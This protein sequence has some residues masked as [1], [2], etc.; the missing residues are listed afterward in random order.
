MAACSLVGKYL[1]VERTYTG[2]IFQAEAEAE[3]EV[4]ALTRHR[5][6]I[7][8]VLTAYRAFWK[9]EHTSV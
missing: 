3:V 2:C 1:R 9:H 8:F 5:H 4:E 6:Q 7:T